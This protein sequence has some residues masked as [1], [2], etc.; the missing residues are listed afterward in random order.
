[1][2]RT[3][4]TEDGS[5]IVVG[6]TAGQNEDLVKHATQRD[7]WFHLDKFPSPHVILKVEGKD[8]PSRGSIFDAQQIAKYLSKKRDASSA[9]VIHVEAK[10]VNGGREDKLGTVA[11]K[12]KPIQASVVYDEATI[13]RLLATET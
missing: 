4:T 13:K 3:M 9:G 2:V 12:K 6:E 10:F 8:G 7:L 1:M 5:T 11:L